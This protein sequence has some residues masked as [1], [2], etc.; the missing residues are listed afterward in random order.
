MRE[1]MDWAFGVSRR[2]L[3]YIAWINNKVLLWGM[4]HYIQYPVIIQNGKEH[5]K[6]IYMSS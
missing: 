3:S 4:G 5:E 6:Y 1:G 2:K